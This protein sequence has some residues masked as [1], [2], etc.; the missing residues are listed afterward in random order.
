MKRIKVRTATITQPARA[1]TG[2]PRRVPLPEAGF[3]S[4]TALEFLAAGGLFTSGISAVAS[5]A[6]CS[7]SAPG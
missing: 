5:N 3:L 6:A 4:A 7:S 2:R 1:R